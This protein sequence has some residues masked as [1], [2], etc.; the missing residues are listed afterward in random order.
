MKDQL[1]RIINTCVPN[2]A[3]ECW[4]RSLG[5]VGH[6]EYAVVSYTQSSK[7]QVYKPTK[8]PDARVSNLGE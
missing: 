5:L 8:R 4:Q 7:Q 1:K 3:F 6:F 2:M